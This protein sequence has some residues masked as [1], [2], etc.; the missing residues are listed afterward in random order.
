MKRLKIFDGNKT[1]IFEKVKQS[2]SS[3]FPVFAIVLLLCFIVF[4]V[5]SGYML[6]FVFG[7]ILVVFGMGF[8][9]LG[10]DSALKPIGEYVGVFILKRKN[11]AWI[12]LLYFIVGTLITIS[13]PDLQVLA[14]QLNG[15]VSG[16]LL[17]F[18]VG[19]G[20]GVFLVIAVLRIVLRL[21]MSILLLCCY[22]A[23]F[24][25][26]FFVPEG[27]LPLA[28]DA[29]GVTTGP[30]SVPFIIAIGTGIASIRSDK[31]SLSDG[32]GLTAI[33][34][35]G[36]IISIMI[37]AIIFK[38]SISVQTQELSEIA[39][40]KTLIVNFLSLIPT[41]VKDVSLGLLPIIGFFF[42]CLL[43]GKKIPKTELVKIILGIIYTYVG[44]ILFLVGV[45]GGFS[46]IGRLIGQLIAVERYRYLIIPVG[47][48]LGFFVV[49]AEPA[50][51]V[52]TKQVYEVTNGE[53]SQK[54]L[55]W[56]LMIGVS[57]SVGLSMAR[58]LLG[59]SAIWFLA[60]G[61]VIAITLS[62]VVPE[63]FTAIAFDAGGVAS[64]AMTA[65]FLLPF[66]IGVCVSMDCN[67]VNAGF[68]LVAF[69]AMTPLITIQVLGLIV[70]IK[71]KKTNNDSNVTVD[72]DRILD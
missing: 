12:L 55:R 54:V 32:F 1:V 10:A 59:I 25:L 8:F 34:S 3:V 52:L 65:S 43:F 47:M 24:I 33:C 49:R 21:K 13:E 51:L 45:S 5:D 64:G 27:F 68:G 56:A 66:A 18:A 2:F 14:T 6:A 57:I 31:K 63:E 70:K 23:V 11:I 36:P 28:F 26:S 58:I 69:V 72:S 29:G 9:S 53:I 61:Y 39:N 60:I 41:C 16:L 19:V 4:P 40:S 35:I 48:L 44:L 42:I 71:R 22:L 30:I 20:V 37:L 67:P 46:N 38:P 17:V 62:F 7:S 15:E 50:V